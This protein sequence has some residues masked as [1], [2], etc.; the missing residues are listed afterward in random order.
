MRRVNACPDL[1]TIAVSAGQLRLR[2]DSVGLAPHRTHAIKSGEE[3]GEGRSEPSVARHRNVTAAGDELE[4]AARDELCG[5]LEQ[6]RAVEAVVT[7]G[8][9]KGRRRDW[10]ATRRQIE[11]IFGLDRSCRVGPVPGTVHQSA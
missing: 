2:A 5:F 11:A 3:S 9:D 7:S 1:R 8:E 4:V 6:R 10:R